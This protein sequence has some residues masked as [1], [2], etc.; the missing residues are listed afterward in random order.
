M[1]RVP[2]R[3]SRRSL[4]VIG[5]L[6]ATLLLA[7]AVSTHAQDRSTF[8]RVLNG[9]G[10]FRVRVQAAF[11]LG[12]TR[13]EAVLPHL[14]RALRD[15]NPAV[16][17]AAASAMGRIGSERAMPALRRAQRDASAAVRLQVSSTIRAIQNREQRQAELPQRRARRPRRAGYFPTVTVIP[18]EGEIQWPRVRY[19]VF[20][21][22]MHNQA[23]FGG[24]QLSTL[25]RSEVWRNLD[26]MR[27]VAV[28]RSPHAVD[29]RAER[30]IRRRRLP[31]L[32]VD[33][34]V[35]AVQRRMQGRDLAVRC[36]VSLVL[37]NEPERALRGELRGAASGSEPR[38]RGGRTEQERR[39]AAQ[40]LEGAVRSAMANARQAIQRAVRR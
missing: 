1:H 31:K 26:L 17:A 33:G 24:D 35:L 25:L 30:E 29:A 23:R 2:H 32:R 39:L 21:G 7:A 4:V 27:H 40:A 34:N 12:N 13:D 5:G 10:D 9:N 6:L 37:L 19:V 16:R 28:M 14:E 20:L 22:D 18:T 3:F 36:E 8:I 38:R 15:S 11:A